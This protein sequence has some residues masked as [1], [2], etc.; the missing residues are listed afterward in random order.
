MLG[1]WRRIWGV[2]VVVG[3]EIAVV[4]GRVVGGHRRLLRGR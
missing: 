4:V 1:Y 2:D 3:V